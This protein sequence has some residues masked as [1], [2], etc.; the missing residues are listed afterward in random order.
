MATLLHESPAIAPGLRRLMATVPSFADADLGTFEWL[1]RD[2]DFG[3]MLRMILG[4]QVSTQA[5]TA[6]ANKLAVLMP[7]SDPKFFLTLSDQQLMSAGFSRRKMRYGRALAETLIR[8]PDFLRRLEDAD[9]ETAIATL[10]QLPGIGRWSAEIY[11]MF[12]LGRPDVWPA[13]DLGIVIGA[14]YL[15]G[16][17]TKPEPEKIVALAEP[18]R[19]Y[20]SAAA[21]LVWRHYAKVNAARRLEQKKPAKGSAE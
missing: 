19:P 20:R 5:A 13:G 18:W 15:L 16:Q 2:A 8:D 4:Q 21:L 14:Q 1:R 9:D 11:L 12:C 3:G 17:D 10:V 7:D 6:M